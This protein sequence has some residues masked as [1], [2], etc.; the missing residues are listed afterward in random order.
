MKNP[1]EDL[2]TRKQEHKEEHPEIPL[3]DRLLPEDQKFVLRVRKL[4]EMTE[5]DFKEKI[6][7]KIKNFLLGKFKREGDQEKYITTIWEL[8]SLHLLELNDSILH[9][10]LIDQG[11]IPPGT[12]I[13]LSYQ[14]ENLVNTI[15]DR[16]VLFGELHFPESRQHYN[17]RLQDFVNSRDVNERLK[18]IHFILNFLHRYHDVPVMGDYIKDLWRWELKEFKPSLGLRD[19]EQT[20]VAFE[21]REEFFGR[22]GS[23]GNNLIKE[24]EQ[25]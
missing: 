20:E 13:K 16:I 23:L 18:G 24:K 6:P 3:F 17:F 4:S 11:E 25:P 14:T 12:P 5:D 9:R 8:V 19:Y 21:K 22:L 15:A 10:E 1:F 2:R 7:I